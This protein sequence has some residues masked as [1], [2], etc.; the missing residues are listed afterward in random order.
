MRLARLIGPELEALLRESPEEV[1]KLTDEI[2]PEDIADVMVDFPTSQAGQLLQRLPTDYAAQVFGRL[3]EEQQRSLSEYLGLERTARIA[4]EMDVD[5][6]A[7]FVGTLPPPQTEGLVKRLERF[8]PEIA[9]DL[10][11]IA[12]WPESSAGGLM[13]TEFV[14]LSPSLLISQAIDV[15]RETAGEVENLDAFYVVDERS[16]VVGLLTLRD[17]LLARPTDKVGEVMHHNVISVPPELDQEEVAQILAKYDLNTL[18]V[19]DSTGEILGIVTSD[20]IL[21]VLSEEQA[22]DV[23]K[24]GAIEPIA[25]GYFDAGFLT[26]IRKRAPWLSV[27][28]VS[29][30]LT[31]SALEAFDPVL[32]A[33]GQLAFYIPLLISAGG[34]SGSQSSTLVIRGLAVGDISSA[35][36]WRVLVRELGQG[37]VLGVLLAAFGVLRVLLFGDGDTKMA[38]LVALTIVAIVTM[39]CIVGGMMPLLLHRLG[40]DPAS[41]STPFIATLVDVLGVIIYLSLAQWL[42]SEVLAHAISS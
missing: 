24:M 19:I 30:Y 5:D 13:T 29:G 14:S 35:D 11:E 37:I 32:R 28:F 1:T 38:L 23:Q 18:P 42:F 41:S 15:L 39:G 31:T 8:D 9:E 36:W 10:E 4:T 21:D 22:E 17:L 34:N 26:Y 7:D 16:R 40:I 3:D 2:H 27:L 20:D 12:R 25:N 6:L 33:L